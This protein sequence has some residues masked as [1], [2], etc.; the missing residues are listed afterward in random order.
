MALTSELIDAEFEKSKIYANQ[1][2]FVNRVWYDQNQ[3]KIREYQI[4]SSIGTT[5]PPVQLHHENVRAAEL[6][7]IISDNFYNSDVMKAVLC[8]SETVIH[9]Q[10]AQ[11]S[12]MS[13]NDRIRTW[14]SGLKQIGSDSVEGVALVAGIDKTDNI[15]VIKAPR[16]ARRDNLQHELFVGVYALNNLRTKVPNFAYIFGGFRCAPPVIGADKKVTSYCANDR[17]NVNYVMYENIAPAMSMREYCRTCT[18]Q[19]FF[20][21]YLQILLALRQAKISCD[22][23]HY[24]LH[25]ENVLIRKLEK[26]I[27][28]AIPYTTESG[29]ELITTDAI[30]TI[31][32][33]GYSH[34]KYQGENFGMYTLQQYG[35]LPDRSFVL[36]D[37]Y[38]LLMFSL[39]S[40]QQNNNKAFNQ[41]AKA[42]RFFN[43][44][45]NINDALSKQLKNFFAIPASL[46]NVRSMSIDVYIKYLRENIPEV[47]AIFV[48]PKNIDILGCTGTDIC[49]TFRQVVEKLHLTEPAKPQS[50]YEFYDLATQ[51]QNSDPQSYNM[52]V[53]SY[54]PI[55][56]TA[57]VAFANEY[58]RVYN[59]AVTKM[60]TI[61][62]YS[63]IQT[64][65]DQLLTTNTLNVY[66]SFVQN[67]ANIYDLSERAA[68][69][70]NVLSY[71][72]TVYND[73][74][75]VNMLRDNNQRLIAAN[76][77]LS[78]VLS[79]LRDD[80][81][82]FIALTTDS[83]WPSIY[84][85][86]QQNLE[87]NW[88]W[89]GRDQ[90][91]YLWS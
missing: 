15:F 1:Q 61:S 36:Y 24:D 89:S 26:K 13:A 19:Q 86:I 47:R 43:E 29:R 32:D 52:L 12:A 20:D 85:K 35:V 63:A 74:R 23:T 62:S 3:Q 16:D 38:K 81:Y 34:V 87:L 90:Y 46:E 27:K 44:S 56:P 21:K 69:M 45:E 41:V 88:Y 6:K 57:A 65:L 55:Y 54:H 11:V 22:Y 82:Y 18:A 28:F 83:R 59:E 58:N 25:D 14:L 80:D 49:F 9:T 77:R 67:V 91:A 40:M 79:S 31:I 17:Y 10:P 73:V 64:P 39:L 84:A 7:S 66:R 42:F 33:Y 8:M 78:I 5:C 71:T 48:T 50:L 70:S 75:A 60:E 37:A 2:E 68:L 30:A 53:K 51:Y 76:E 72:S 4:I